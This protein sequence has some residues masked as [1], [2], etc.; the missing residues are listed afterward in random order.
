MIKKIKLVLFFLIF[1]TLYWQKNLVREVFANTV[2]NE[3]GGE[4][5]LIHRVGEY[6]STNLN[7]GCYIGIITCQTENSL[8][9][10]PACNITVESIVDAKRTRLD[11]FNG[12]F[13]NTAINQCQCKYPYTVGKYCETMDMCALTDCGINGHCADGKCVCDYGFEGEK[14]QIRKD[15]GSPNKR[16]DGYKCSCAKGYEGNDCDECIQ[17]LVCVPTK[18]NSRGYTPLVVTDPKLH[19]FILSSSPPEGYIVKP[20]VPSVLTHQCSCDVES[21][22]SPPSSSALV[23]LTENF[24]SF[25]QNPEEG[26]HRSIPKHIDYIHHLY[27]KHYLTTNDCEFS[28]YFWIVAGFTFLA[29]LLFIIF[30]FS[31]WN[32]QD[33]HHSFYPQKLEKP[34][35]SSPFRHSPIHSSSQTYFKKQDTIPIS[36][37]RN[38]QHN[39]GNNNN[40]GFIVMTYDN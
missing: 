8:M 18:I 37:P 28:S 9:C 5:V 7:N 19:E 2:L 17:G 34:H 13:Y 38:N 21:S 27:E 11:C 1:S 24:A 35:D 31:H 25:Y 3:C 30:C 40:G 32:R 33:H 10:V 4:R 12:G 16:W 22:Y 15:C 14:C 36:K 23:S 39:N 20:F 29:F 26:Y 6:C